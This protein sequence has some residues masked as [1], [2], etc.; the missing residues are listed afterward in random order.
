M[1][2]AAL[3]APHEHHGSTLEKP[4]PLAVVALACSEAIALGRAFRP[5]IIAAHP[6]GSFA[7]AQALHANDL[8]HAPSVRLADPADG[9]LI[10]EVTMGH[11]PNPSPPLDATRNHGARADGELPTAEHQGTPAECRAVAAMA[12]L[13]RHWGLPDESSDYRS[14]LAGFLIRAGVEPHAVIECIMAVSIAAGG[15]REPSTHQS[16]VLLV[17]QRLADGENV[18]GFDE[19]ARHVGKRV[20]AQAAEWLGL[21]PLAGTTEDARE[22][23]A[24]R[25]EPTEVGAP[26]G[27]S[28]PTSVRGQSA[29]AENEAPSER[30]EI[31]HDGV[32][33]VFTSRHHK[34]AKYDHSAGRWFKWDGSRWRIDEIHEVAHRLRLLARE[35]TEDK[36]FAVQRPA[37]TAGFAEC[38]ERLTQRNRDHAVTQ[39]HWD[40]DPWLLGTPG[41]TVDLKTGELLAPT[42]DAY[43]TKQAAIT[44][45]EQSNC[46]KWKTFLD[47]ATGGDAALIR[48]LQQFCGYC[49][50]GETREHAL[51]FLYGPGGNGKSVF[52]NTIMG[53]IGD[54]ATAASMDTFTASKGERHPTDLAMLRGARLA[55]ASETEEGKPW[56]ESRIKQLTG[57]D[58]IS[59]RFMRQDFFS[60]RPHFKLFIAGNHKPILV[61]VDDA[62]RRRFNMVPFVHRPQN[63]D[64][65]LEA[66]LRSEWPQILRW[67]IEGCL[68]WQRDGLERPSAVQ[69]ATDAYFDDQDL[70]GQWL[71]DRCIV[72]PGD[73]GRWC[74]SSTLYASW[75]NYALEAGED[76]GTA[77]KF[78]ANLV[79]RGL[80]QQRRSKCRGYFGISLS[81]VTSYSVEP[82]AY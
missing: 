54:Y 72:A 30:I 35:L 44:P 2:S 69:A 7:L 74:A 58:T 80:M 5:N 6:R 79:K 81:L 25:E 73:T 46:T 27:G 63:P 17:E 12:L 76:P 66:K 67:M 3:S 55:S 65:T 18:S 26:V 64:R 10:L 82:P 14:A 29:N 32:A 20:A 13:A 34:T 24:N 77:K 11:H 4:S 60:F 48:F 38:V 9:A 43:I 47:E 78:S 57:G 39:S 70:F 50:T 36:E 59:A 52:L 51:L 56:A 53:I 28:A 71:Q 31:T 61:N 16:A 1:S 37:R 21:E 42:P 41:G 49:L 15:R 23:A 75:K 8:E 40:R 33:R 19:L 22:S 68:D 62:A 45:A